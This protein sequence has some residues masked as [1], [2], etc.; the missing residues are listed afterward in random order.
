MSRFISGL[1]IYNSDVCENLWI[2]GSPLVYESDLLKAT[3]TVPKGFVT[4]L[5]SVP[6]MPFLYFYWGG[7]AHREAVIH[8]Y[9]YRT[10]SVPLATFRQANGVLLEAMASRGKSF[11]LRWTMWAGVW[12]GGY[13]QYHKKLVSW[14]PEGTTKESIMAGP[15]PASK[16]P[17]G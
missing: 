16:E 7:R 3:V 2:L 5:A 1:D 17:P 6:R 15:P 4:D 13:F 14:T 12:I 10:D 8:D 9:L 11:S